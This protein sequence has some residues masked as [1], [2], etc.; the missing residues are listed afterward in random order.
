MPTLAPEVLKWDLLWAVWS[1]SWGNRLRIAHKARA[2]VGEGG[3]ASTHGEP[4]GRETSAGLALICIR[5]T[6]TGPIM[7]CPKLLLRLA[8][9]LSQRVQ[10]PY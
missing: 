8:A 2:S 4:L 6:C 9:C 3:E 7:R 5:L 10:R 1:R